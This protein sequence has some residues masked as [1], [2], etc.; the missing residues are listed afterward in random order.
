MKYN[1]TIDEFLQT[2]RVS[3]VYIENNYKIPQRDFRCWKKGKW[4]PP[5]FVTNLLIANIRYETLIPSSRVRQINQNLDEAFSECIGKNVNDCSP[6][7]IITSIREF[8]KMTPTEFSKN[9]GVP[10]STL[11]EW[12]RNRRVPKEYALCM[13]KRIT[14]YSKEING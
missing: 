12:E 1:Q 14:V 4:S 5:G 11:R 6:G 2:S 8:F 7:E 13:F 10:Y 3:D 9:F